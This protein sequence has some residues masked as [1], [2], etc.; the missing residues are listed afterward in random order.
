MGLFNFFTK[1]KREFSATNSNQ[2]DL[3]KILEG[4]TKTPAITREMAM[5]I[6]ALKAGIGFIADLVSSLEIEL[7]LFTI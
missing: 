3:T 4:S 1:E 2:A 5:Q 7:S 6:P